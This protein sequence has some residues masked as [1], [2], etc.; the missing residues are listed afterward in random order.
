MHSAQSTQWAGSHASP[1]SV[2]RARRTLRRP[3]GP[4]RPN[5]PNRTSNSSASRSHPP[6]RSYHQRY[7]RVARRMTARITTSVQPGNTSSSQMKRAT[8]TRPA[9]D[10][11]RRDFPGHP[12]SSNTEGR[13]TAQ[14]VSGGRKGLRRPGIAQDGD[15]RP[16]QT[17]IQNSCRQG[18]AL[19]TDRRMAPYHHAARQAGGTRASA[20]AGRTASRVGNGRGMPADE[21][22]NHERHG[23][24]RGRSPVG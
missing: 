3:R 8:A 19:T 14:R 23:H 13:R 1:Q 18:S 10:Q 21:D 6:E 24:G 22:R 15:G 12:K 4:T 9:S 17:K 7:G 5:Q 11:C 20:P 2:Q 16:T